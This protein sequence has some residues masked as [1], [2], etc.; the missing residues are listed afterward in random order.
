MRSANATHMTAK[1]SCDR[2]F[3]VDTQSLP[4]K[5]SVR[6]GSVVNDLLSEPVHRTGELIHLAEYADGAIGETF[7]PEG[8]LGSFLAYKKE[9]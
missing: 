4:A 1:P 5:W 6:R 3:K 9:Q 2:A 7:Q 8:F